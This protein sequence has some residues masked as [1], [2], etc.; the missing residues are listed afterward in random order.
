MKIDHYIVTFMDYKQQ[1]VYAK[2]E[3]EAMLLGQ[4]EQIKLGLNANVVTVGKVS[5]FPH[6]N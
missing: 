5:W 6:P 4:A 1:D 3:K 2:T